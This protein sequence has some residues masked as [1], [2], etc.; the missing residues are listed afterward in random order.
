M[1][2]ARSLLSRI[3]LT[4]LVNMT[5][6]DAVSDTSCESD[7]VHAK[8]ISN[9]ATLLW[10]TGACTICPHWLWLAEIITQAK[11]RRVIMNSR[12]NKNCPNGI[13]RLWGVSSVSV[14]SVGQ[15]LKQM[16]R[17]QRGYKFRILHP[18]THIVFTCYHGNGKCKPHVIKI[19]ISIQIASYLLLHHSPLFL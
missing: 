14:K 7:I 11:R 18:T 10:F 5:A 19:T 1:S 16:S 4:K 8:C 13:S 12:C 15:M 3:L 9:I 6:Y 17:V 2:V